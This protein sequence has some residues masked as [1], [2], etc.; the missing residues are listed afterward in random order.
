MKYSKIISVMLILLVTSSCCSIMLS[1]QQ[2]VGIASNPSGAKVIIDGQEVG[3]TPLTTSLARKNNHNVKIELD[4]FMPYE[5]HLTKKTSG[6]VFGNIIFG[7]IIG[8]V[9]DLATG[10]LYVLTPEDIQ[11]NLIKSDTGMLNNEDIL[12]FAFV[13]EPE[14]KWTKI[15]N[16]ERK[17]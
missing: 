11:A 17:N 12:F 16:L 1:P 3:N 13:L 14:T 6:W 9:V 8:L 2:E 10:A 5:L 15:G 7:G 4:G